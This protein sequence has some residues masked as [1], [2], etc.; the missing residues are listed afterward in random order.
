[1]TTVLLVDDDAVFRGLA[2][3]MLVVADAGDLHPEAALVD[4]MLAGGD[5]VALAHELAELPWRPRVLLTSTAPARCARSKS[6]GSTCLRFPQ[7]GTKL[8]PRRPHG[9]SESTWAG[10]SRSATERFR[11]LYSQVELEQLARPIAEVA[12]QARETHLLM[13]NCYRDDAVRSAAQLR[14]PISLRIHD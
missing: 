4:V 7:I 3:H 6:G 1:M 2:R 13:D 11:Y 14:D 5:G 8:R 10:P 9:R 12:H